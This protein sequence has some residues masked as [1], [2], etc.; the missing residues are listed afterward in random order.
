MKI[1]SISIKN[2]RSLKNVIIHSNDIL[3]LVG[4]NSSGKSNVIKALQVFFDGS[5]KLISEN[6]FYNSQTSNQIEILVKF[7]SLSDRDLNAFKNEL[8][9][10]E[11]TV[12]R[13]IHTDS[14]GKVKVTPI[15][16]TLV[17]EPEW[18]RQHAI[19]QTSIDSWWEK[20]E[21]LKF[22][23]LNFGESLGDSKPS[24]SNWKHLAVEKH[25]E[26]KDEI[27]KVED[28]I[29]NA[30][31]LNARLREYLPEFIY[32]PAVR[33]VSDEAKIQKTNPFGQIIS[34]ILNKVSIQ[35]KELL[36]STLASLSKQL[37]RSD[38]ERLGAITEFENDLREL[39]GELYECDIELSIQIP[40][41]EE[42]FSKTQIFADDGFRSPIEEK[43]HGM[44]R[45][46]IFTILRAYA[47]L[48]IDQ[49]E[50]SGRSIIFGIEEPELYLHPSYQRLFMQ[51]LRTIS[52]GDDQVM[53]STQSSSFV[54]VGY[55]DEVCLM[56]RYKKDGDFQSIPTQ[57]SMT[58]IL[59]DLKSRKKVDA[60]P[61]SM[62]EH[63]SNAFYPDASE[64]FFSDKVVIVE[65]PSE[66][67]C[68]PIYARC[69]GFDFDK[70]N[71]VIVHSDGKGQMDRLYRVFN[72]FK[73]PVYL[74]F[75]GDKSSGD[76]A[77]REKTLELLEL[78][79]KS[80]SGISEV[81][82]EIASNYSVFSECIEETLQR[83][84]QHFTKYWEIAPS[85]LGPCGKPLKHRFT[86]IKISDHVRMSLDNCEVPARIE[87]I[88][89][90]MMNAQFE[91]SILEKLNE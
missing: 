47:K 62:R 54:S 28:I 27:N 37:N 69:L 19:N 71:I 78:L 7:H 61:S 58:S 84:S 25:L 12:G 34:S 38:L 39:F 76:K 50:P 91:G 17:P 80:V 40:R 13:R 86:A 56:R 8:I 2:F 64:G 83:E 26:Y 75:D 46:M 16:V 35:E 10:D 36:N 67:Y 49:T 22:G 77:T 74:L 72:G 65:G 63:Y 68:L 59:D 66:K 48:S 32:I 15:L 23:N 11:L 42:L 6:S 24:V 57:L 85:E 90:A 18:L 70:A 81:T 4:R 87:K 43:G 3:A 45:S 88:I 51:L 79:G 33:E 52:D 41:I 9:D 55:F 1:K 44:Q 20:K 29:E 89:E 5:T 31:G 60:T 73:L 53:Y 21:E 82:D 14:N 30:T